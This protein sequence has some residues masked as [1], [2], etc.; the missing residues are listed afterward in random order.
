MVSRVSGFA[1]GVGA[2][3]LGFTQI[4]ARVYEL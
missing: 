2:E 4:V 1:F 3:R